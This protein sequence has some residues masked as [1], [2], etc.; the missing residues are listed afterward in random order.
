VIGEQLLAMSS[1][2]VNTTTGEI[3]ESK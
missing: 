2:Q 3:V 1:Q